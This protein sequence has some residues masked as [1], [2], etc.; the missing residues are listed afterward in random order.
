[1]SKRWKV[2]KLNA[3]KLEKSREILTNF[4]DGLIA[5]LEKLRDELARQP[6]PYN[7]KGPTSPE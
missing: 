3:A 5:R 4:Y 6:N 7:E 1:M 2:R